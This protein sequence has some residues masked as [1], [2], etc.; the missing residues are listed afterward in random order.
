[1]TVVVGIREALSVSTFTAVV[2]TAFT[3]STGTRVLH[4]VRTG[5]VRTVPG[6]T[7]HVTALIDK[8]IQ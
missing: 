2:A 6:I 1:M 5:D 8:H 3:N 7:A 4:R